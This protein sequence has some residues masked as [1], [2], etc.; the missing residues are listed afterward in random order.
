M[1]TKDIDISGF[2]N[3][4]RLSGREWLGV[5]VF[6]VL[7]IVLAP[8]LWQHVEKFESEPDYRI[9]YDLSYDYWLYDRYSR[10]AAD[11]HDTLLVGDSV[12]WG[13]YVTRQQTLSHYLNE[14][15]GKERFANLGLDG[16]HPMALAGLMEFYAGGL[17]NKRVLIQCNPLWMSSPRHDL[18]IDEDFR[19]NHPRLVS[20]FSPRIPCYREEISPKL[21]IIVEQRLPFN[22]W[23][24]H[25][26]QAHFE[27][28]SIPAW[29]LEH[30][31]ENPLAELTKELPPSDNTLRHSPVS[32]VERGIKAQNYPWVDPS[33]SLQWQAFWQA[34][35]ILQRRGNRVFVLLGPFN[36]HLL[37]VESC[38][39]YGKLKGTLE[40]W[41]RDNGIPCT[42][43]AVL[44]SD[45]YA[46]AS[47]PLSVGYATL[48]EWM[49]KDPTFKAWQE[50]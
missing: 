35:A 46:D 33:T 3:A 40:D 12:V 21:G 50:K 34:V 7:L 32:W 28:M 20:Q 11:T 29:T 26:Q 18:Q 23:T 49:W 41:F 45:Q 19:F 4:I 24:Q 13:Q 37:S 48:A 17:S 31:Y 42:A 14:R 1:G 15:A 30:P 9:P 5:A 2:S 43:L 10:L 8:I 47:H 39:R 25:L 36:E 38:E 22:S 44:P 6:A 27:K 16:S